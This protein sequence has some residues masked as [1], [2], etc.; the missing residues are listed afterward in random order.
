MDIR[1]KGGSGLG[2]KYH[3]SFFQ[4]VVANLLQSRRTRVTIVT[5]GGE[6]VVEGGET[7]IDAVLVD[8]LIAL[9]SAY[10]ME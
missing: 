7:E 6:E 5:E 3:C 1:Y 9:H 8:R 4:V 10:C 2:D